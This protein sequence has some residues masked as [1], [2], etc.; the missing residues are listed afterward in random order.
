M[1]LALAVDRGSGEIAV[2]G[3]GLYNVDLGGGPVSM[4]NYNGFLA[5]YDANGNFLW[6][7]IIAGP[8]RDMGYDVAI[9]PRMATSS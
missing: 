3:Y 1:A 7:R 2:T 4:A 8:G 5:K 6:Q 9:D